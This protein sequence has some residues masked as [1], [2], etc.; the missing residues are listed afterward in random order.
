MKKLALL[1]L[2]FAVA[3]SVC[4]AQFTSSMQGVIQDPSRAVIPGAS[5]S[6]RNTQTGI[7]TSGK[8][9]TEGVYQFVSLQPGNYE[10]TAKADGFQTVTVQVVL[11]TSQTADVNVTLPVMSTSQKIQ[12]LASATDL[13]T[14]DSRIEATITTQPLEDLPMKGRNVYALAAVAPGVTGLMSGSL[15]A[16]T[17]GESEAPD[18]F[19]PAKIVNISANGRGFVGNQFVVDGLDVGGNIVQGSVDLSPNPDAID[20]I[21]VQTDTFSAENGKGSSLVIAI[22]TK[23]GTNQFHGTGSYFFSDQDLWARTEF[24]NK[25]YPFSRNDLS[26][27]VGG[28]IVKNKTF[29]LAS[30]ELLRSRVTQATGITTYESPQFVNWATQ[31]YPNSI[32]TKLLTAYPITNVATTGTLLTASNVFGSTCGTP[33]TSGIPCDLAMVDEGVIEPSPYRNGLQFG[34]R[35]DQYLNNG[36]DRI[37]GNYMRATLDTQNPAFRTGMGSDNTNDTWGVQLNYTHTFS[38]TLINEAAAGMTYVNGLDVASGPFQIPDITINQQA[39]GIGVGWGPGLFAQRNYNW[40]DVLNLVRGS[41]TVRFG[42]QGWH[43]WDAALWQKLYSRPTFGFNNL[44]DLVQDQPF[45]EGEVAYDPLTGQE[46]PL[47][48][49]GGLSGEGV[50]VQDQWKAKA[51]LSLSMGIRWDDFGN[52]HGENGFKYSNIFLGQGSTTDEQFANASVF[53]SQNAFASRMDTNFS[54]RLGV[55]WD[56]SRNGRWSI[57][58]GVGVFHDWVTLGDSVDQVGYNPPGFLTPSFTQQTP[59]QPLLSIGTSSTY[60]YGFQYP[61]IPTTGL[62]AHGGLVGVDEGVGGLDRNLKNPM[63]V[64]WTMGVEHQLPRK[65]VAGISYTGS[66]TWNAVVGTDFNREAGDLL[67]DDVLNRPNPNFGAMQYRFNMNDIHYQ[68]MILSIRSG[69]GFPIQFQSSYTYGHSTDYGQAGDRTGTGDLFGEAD[70]PDQHNI[71]AYNFGDADWDVRHRFTFSGYYKLPTPGIDNRFMKRVLGGWEMTSVAIL[72]TGEPFTVVNTSPFIPTLD[73]SGQVT[74]LAPGS[75]DYNADGDDYD[76]PNAPSPL[77]Q[78]TGSHSRQQFLSGIFPASAFPTPTLGTE[79]NEHRN[80]FRNP[81]IIS[82]D[83]GMIKN[84]PLR[85]LGEHG[86]LELRFDF[87]NVLNHPN[88]LGVDNGLT[89]ADFGKVTNTRDPRIIQLGARIVF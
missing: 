46:T 40:R 53:A 36:K 23:S 73:S 4:L 59:I 9:S 3:E 56:P 89:D 64:N 15:S 80:I 61:T 7:V 17:A 72:Q 74:G 57:R 29:F 1:V 76:Y 58:G 84:N 55:A 14:A 63:T 48:Y 31:N 30:V 45:S 42:V 26:G 62:N 47:R 49:M 70:F 21:A 5:V 24:T 25:Y 68:A 11:I 19:S 18:N 85:W 86:N 38:P 20:E 41:H 43:G 44:L 60:P 22:T 82:L 12:V 2:A 81:G 83:S 78:F 28:P 37:F 10:L 79:G 67:P 50:F 66:R 32:G 35:L 87:Y 27:V 16:Q 6:L 39:Q 51:N 88:L 69:F 8:S 33:A 77:G 54:P 65:L 75:G 34:L 71:K 13:D 52:P